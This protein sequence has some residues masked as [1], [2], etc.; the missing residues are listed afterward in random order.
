MPTPI[1]ARR[2]KLLFELESIIGNQFHNAHI[3]N[4]GPGGVFEGAGREVRYPITFRKTDGTTLKFKSYVPGNEVPTSIML[5]GHYVLG[6]NHLAIMSALERVLRHLEAKYGLVVE[7][8]E[9]GSP[10]EA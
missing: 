7:R 3:Q 8:A 2:R 10:G 6:A 5:S 9:E 4:Y 1:S